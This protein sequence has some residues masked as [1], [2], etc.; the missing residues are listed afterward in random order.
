[1]AIPYRET[2]IRDRPGVYQ[3]TVNLDDKTETDNG[4]TPGPGPDPPIIVCLAD[5]WSY[6]LLDEKERTLL[7]A[8]EEV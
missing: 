8:N 5:E 4:G 1:M 6:T 7:D 3:R 2:D